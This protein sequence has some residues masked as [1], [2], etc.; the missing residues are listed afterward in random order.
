MPRHYATRICLL[1]L[2]LLGV[3]LTAWSAQGAVAW[4]AALTCGLIAVQLGFVAHDAGHG[5]ISSKRFV[6]Q[7]AGQFTFTFVNGLG[8]QSWC[9]SHNAHHAHC[10]DESRDPDMW[11]DT[12]MSLT[13]K[14]ASEKTGISKKLLPYQGYYLWPLAMFFGHNLRFQ[15]IL[16]IFSQMRRYRADAFMMPLHYGLWF[17]IPMLVVGVGFG[18]VLAV[19][20]IESSVAGVYMAVVFWVN[21]IGMPALQ[22][23]HGLSTLQQQVQG[24][25]NVRNPRAFDFFFGGLNFQIEHHLVPTCPSTNLRRIQAITRPILLAESLPYPEEG[26][27][28]APRD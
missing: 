10:Q 5:A 6:N 12:M 7:I 16:K 8:F 17:L 18:R 9:D 14:S 11:V 22:E 15:S 19:Y 2:L 28:S 20:L 4:I 23:D 27:R 26:F 24:S 25:R 21:H 1:S 3:Q 13:P